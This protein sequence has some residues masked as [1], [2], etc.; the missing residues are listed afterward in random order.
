M[1]GKTSYY[2]DNDEKKERRSFFLKDVNEKDEAN[3]YL[4]LKYLSI[5]Y[6]ILE[7][8]ICL[9]VNLGILST[10]GIITVS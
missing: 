6:E 2:Y 8:F 7:C 10:I 4:N 3:T 9:E 1:A 5:V